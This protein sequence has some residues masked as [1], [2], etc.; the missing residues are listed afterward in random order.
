M[1]RGV[2]GEMWSCGAL[3]LWGTLHRGMQVHRHA[4][5]KWGALGMCWDKEYVFFLSTL[6][7]SVGV[8]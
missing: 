1:G 3:A 5:G 6:H 8:T 7:R 4:W 2:A